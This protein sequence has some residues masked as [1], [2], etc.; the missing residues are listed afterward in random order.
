MPILNYTTMVASAKTVN[1]IQ[2]IL[3]KHG[4]KSILINY[5]DKGSVESLSFLVNTPRGEVGIKLPVNPDAV[6]KVLNKQ[7]VPWRYRDREHAVRIAWRILKV[8]VQAQMALIETEMVNLDQVFLPYVEVAS[9]KT[10]YQ[11][12]QEKQ[13]NLLGSGSEQHE[14]T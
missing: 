10:V 3:A 5:N 9:G 6:L 11:L 12:F 13:Q 4:A 14:K 7:G 8:W 1:E 2:S